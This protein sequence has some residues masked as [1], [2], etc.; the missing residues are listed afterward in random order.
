MPNL[1]TTQKYLED[2]AKLIG[3]IETKCHPLS[4][5]AY[6]HMTITDLAHIAKALGV[7]GLLRRTRGIFPP[8]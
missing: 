5:Y 6:H 4:D 1:L 2:R 7:G 3:L 8:N